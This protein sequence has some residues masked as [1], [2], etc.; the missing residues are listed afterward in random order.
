MEIESV[1]LEKYPGLGVLELEV[2]DVV[3][4]KS[5]EDLEEFKRKKQEEIRKRI[6]SLDAVKD[7]PVLRAYRDFYWKV[8]IDPTKTRPAGEALIRRIL[9]GRD[10]P[11]VNTLVD[12]YNVA[13]AESMVAIAAFDGR[14]VD[15]SNLLMRTVLK[16]EVF[17][18][19]GMELPISLSGIE[20]VIQDRTSEKLVAVY[21]YRDSDESKVTEKTKDVLFMMCGVPGISQN[22]LV[23][24]NEMTRD[25]VSRFCI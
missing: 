25:Y 22:D 15:I 9:G 1:L 10:L 20:V 19:I 24:A 12:S 11:T 4:K 3:V 14:V 16:G 7:L 5:S 2:K 23:L 21:P 18:G 17:R 13:S 6:P 8:G